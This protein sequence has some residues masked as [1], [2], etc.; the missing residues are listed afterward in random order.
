MKVDTII[1]LDNDKE[2]AL[3]EK[4]D[5]EGKVY[6]FA[7]GINSDEQA[8]GEYIFIEQI[9]KGDKTFIQKVLDKKLLAKLSTIITKE[10]YEATESLLKDNE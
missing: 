2:Y 1:T 10:Y 8:T 9:I 6:F 4:L 3:L 7:A 5:L